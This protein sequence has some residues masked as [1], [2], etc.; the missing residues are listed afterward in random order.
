MSRYQ[1]YYDDPSLWP[2]SG[3]GVASFIMALASSLVL[4]F[5]IVLAVILKVAD[6]DLF[7]F[8]STEDLVVGGGLCVGGLLLLTSAGLGLGGLAQ[9]RRKKIFPILGLC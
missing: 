7:N 4:L 1:E 6:R 3:V 9:D 8:S 2:H 5:M